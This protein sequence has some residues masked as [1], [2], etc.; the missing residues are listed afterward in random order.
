M[1]A[2]DSAND[3]RITR[4]YDAP[5][6]LVWEVWTVDVHV[7]Q[8]WG[9]RGFSLTTHSKDLHVGGTWVYT[10]HGPDGVDYPNYTRYLEVEPLKR[11]VYDHGASSADSA[12]MFRVTATFREVGGQT[13]LDMRMTLP[14][15]QAAQD[16][17]VFIKAAGGNA[18]W[19]RLGEHL[20]Q[21]AHD[22]AVF[23]INRSFDA[24]IETVF[25]MWTMPEHLVRWL[26]P[27]GFDMTYI[28]ADVRVGASSFFSMSNGAM[29]MYGVSEYR[30]IQ[31]PTRVEYLH[32]FADANEQLSRHP[33]APTWPD[34]MLQT[35]HLVAEG[36]MQ[37]RV[38]IRTEVFGAATTEQKAVFAEA[39]GGMT[40]GWTGSFDKLEVLVAGGTV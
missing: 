8:W 32:W 18:T 10:M 5:L 39:R 7:K 11:L 2:T 9:P 37:T 19:D 3:I 1:T 17:R 12:P 16:A 29:T 36:A 4:L 15:P 34:K 23:V 30:V 24:P 26:P 35:V 22:R 33:G 20:E 38:T 28:R 13:E 31:R 25:D 27:T 21:T 14:T 40:Q 6:A